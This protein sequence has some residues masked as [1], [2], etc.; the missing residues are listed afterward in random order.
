MCLLAL[1]NIDSVFTDAEL[2]DFIASNNDGYG[3]MRPATESYGVVTYKQPTSDNF[4]INFRAWQDMT[5]A[6]G[7]TEFAMHTR[8]RTH[9]DIDFHN[10]HPHKVTDDLWLMHNG[11]LSISTKSNAKNS[12]TIHYIEQVIN[13]LLAHTALS[14]WQEPV[15]LGLIG[16]SIGHSNKFIM[17]T[18]SG[19]GV[20]NASAGIEFRGSWF[21]NTY[22]WSIWDGGRG[23]REK[24]FDW[25]QD[26]ME[27]Y[28]GFSDTKGTKQ[29][30]LPEPHEPK[31]SQ[32]SEAID[33]FVEEVDYAAQAHF[34]PDDCPHA[35][36]IQG[37]YAPEAVMALAH[38]IVETEGVEGLDDYLDVLFANLSD[39]EEIEGLDDEETVCLG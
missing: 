26:W 4:V 11:I 28:D 31:F 6:S 21:S 19:F 25:K 22:A 24:K 18:P 39:E 7:Q 16:D 15:L 29:S 3:F 5:R 8:M 13:P 2:L 9:G 37:V 1:I 33:Y 17:C 23:R 32:L 35:W 20:V 30:R 10:A 27:G 38:S 34:T 14:A 36:Q 12:D